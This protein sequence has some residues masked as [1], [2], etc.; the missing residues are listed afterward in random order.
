MMK[1][2]IFVLIFLMLIGAGLQTIAAAPDGGVPVLSAVV[3]TPDVPL[4]THYSPPSVVSPISPT[5]GPPAS[6]SPVGIVH[7]PVMGS[8]QTGQSEQEQATA[9]VNASKAAPMMNQSYAPDRVIVKFK[10]SGLSSQSSVSQIQAEAHAALGAMVIADAKTLGVEGMQVVSVPNSTGTMKAIGLYKM[11]PMVEYAQPDYIYH[12]SPV[13]PIHIPVQVNEKAI[14]Y[15]TNVVQGTTHVPSTGSTTTPSPPVFQNPAVSSGVSTGPL[16]ATNE[17]EGFGYMHFSLEDVARIQSEYNAA[18]KVKNAPLSTTLGSKSLLSNIQYTPSERNQGNCGNCWVW[19]STGV[20]ENALTVQNGIK[21]RLSIQYFDSN[22]NGGS[23][24]TGACNGGW[25]STFA[26][27]YSTSGFKQV[28]PWSNTNAYYNDRYACSYGCGAQTPASSI[29]TTPNHPVTSISTSWLS[30][31]SVSQ[32]QAIANIKA[33]IDANKAV[34]WAF[35]LPDSSSWSAF[36]SY[37]SGQ[38]E[39][40][41]WNPDTYNNKVYGS[42]G[43]GHAVIIVGYDDSSSDPNQRY[44]IVLNSWGSNS[45]RLNGLFRLKMNMDYSG[46]SSN[47]YQSHYF[48]IFNVNYGASTQ[49]G[50]IYNSS[51][52]T[53]ARIW[54]DGTDTG[55]NTPN[56]LSSV[57]AG[58][59]SVTY[60]LTNYND[61]VTTA[62]VTGGQTTT[63]QGSLTP[64]GSTS[65]ISNDPYASYLWG[66]HNTGQTGGI[67]DADIDAPEAWAV[68]KGSTSVIVGVVDSG[69]DYNHPD[70][71]ANMV[72]GYNAITGTTNPMDD[73]GHGTHCAGTIGAV[74]NNGIGVVGVNWN[75]KIMPLKFLDEDGYGYTSD[76]IEAFGWGYSRGVR[77]FSNSWGGYGTD[78]ALQD[79]ISQY[80]D[81]LFICAAGNDGSNTDVSPQSPSAL[82]NANI[83][84]VA[85]TDH[86]DIL[87]S[88]SNYGASTVDVAAPGVNIYSTYP[89]S[90]YAYMDGTSMATPHVA[91][92]AALVKAANSGYTVVQVKQA[93]LGGVDV[94]SGLSGKCVTGGRVNAGN[95]L[96][97]SQINNAQIISHTI[98]STMTAGQSY[99]VSV[100]MK[101]TGASTWTESNMIRFGGVEFGD[102]T[103]PLFGVTRILLPTG[104]S[105][106]PGSTYSFSFTLTA[107][108]AGTY[109]PEY[110]MLQERVEWFGESLKPVIQVNARGNNAQIISHTIPSTMT[111]GQSYSVSVTMK[112]TGT[113]TWTESNMIRFGGVE[114]GDGTAPLFGVTRILLPTGTSVAP[115]STYSFSF[116]L[117]APGAGTYT[118]EYRMLQERVEWFG[119]SL[120]PVIQVNARGNNA[121][122]ISHTIPSTMTAGQSYSVSVTMKNT[123]TS[124]WTESNMIRFGGVEFGD[125]TAPLFGV[126]RILLPTGTSVAPGSTY[127]FSFTLTAPGAGTYTP[128]YRMLQERVEW[129]GESLKPVIQVN[130]RGNNAQI[131][132]HTIP[133]TMTAGQSYSVSVTMKNTG[134]STWTESNMIRFGG[135]EFG[136]GTA[137]LFGVTRI[138]L[139]TG[140]S[141]AP[142]STYSFSFTLTAP[143]AGTYTPEYRMLQERVEWFGESLKPVI[144]V[145]ARENNAQIIS[146]TIPSTMTA[147]QSYSVSVTMKNTGTSTW[148]ESNMIRFGGVEF[149]DGTAPLFG[150]TRILLPTGT[151]VAPGSTYSFSFTLT[152]PGAGTYT[153]EYRMLQER[154]E[155]FG[156]SLKP[157]IQ[158]NA[159]GNNAQIIS[160]TIPS[161]MTAGQSYSVS[162]T[163]K[164]TGT[165][166][167]TE[168]NMIR[169]GGV[170]F[171][172]GTAPLFGVTRILLPTGSSV[173]PGS[174][175]S[176]SF[177]LT[178]PGAGTYTPEYRMLQ[179]RVEW[180]GESLK[181]V[182]Q[183]NV[184]GNNAQIISHTIPSTMT[185]G[186]SYSVSVTMKNTG[187]STWTESNMIRFGGVEFGD[188]TAPLFGVT[189]ILLPTG[190]SVAPGSTYSFSFT[191]TAPGAGTYTPEY[192]ML[193]E[194]VEW[195]GESLKPVIQV[196]ARGNNAQIHQGDVTGFQ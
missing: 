161:T 139:P 37:W 114:F 133:S 21:D 134:T 125:G 40:A 138:L 13:E 156:E 22:Y 53:G 178:A 72:G 86:R 128:E 45:G 10:T 150:V 155:W 131:I 17:S 18:V 172:D 170:E 50:S 195:F 137:P 105:V 19:A 177:T 132:S 171:G 80:S 189:R 186:Q 121:Q 165:S 160:H 83:I 173:A 30:T 130:A 154:V 38:T 91:G 7:S 15:R 64:S 126:T 147:G 104:T 61:Y 142:G 136:D 187:T 102:G 158:V 168:S 162:V 11:N 159:R 103:A 25:A 5:S 57:T 176:F 35:F 122:I 68:T 49:T 27:F 182:I 175:Y 97:S 148:T 152:A 181:P 192:R 65:S 56:T 42:S 70:L 196:N 110:R 194:R 43:G 79:A 180:F 113:S 144:Q 71:A 32:E 52:P 141:V 4:P 188:G 106:A 41:L 145:N 99:S 36:S 74:G 123:G 164:N 6:R 3:K 163:M 47:G 153:P 82:P 149:G 62:T 100:T 169:F 108:G 75:V 166:T 66:L 111:A 63:V 129:F 44:W 9:S 28:I 167:W 119:E 143:G 84:A 96:S 14:S 112:N 54:L 191:L 93:I 115:G 69:V 88:F 24:T 157:V 33:Q 120:K 101:N 8:Y 67:V 26:N 48:S 127:S 58:T 46:R 140:S 116:T 51:N 118:P 98:P 179:E 124:T 76:A 23:A 12:A 77:I 146:H 117:T 193:Q 135:V 16:S 31:Y 89:G 2:I 85:A 55:K 1:Q 183:V 20:I 109:T 174:T 39:A 184:R 185:A 78:T 90:S 73:N 60:K 92:V 95:A 34:W 87:A 94:K 151:S 29:S 190:T 107:P 81:A 59:H